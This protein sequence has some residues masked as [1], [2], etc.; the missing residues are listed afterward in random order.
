[1]TAGRAF[2]SVKRWMVDNRGRRQRSNFSVL[3]G[4]TANEGETHIRL[5]V[6]KIR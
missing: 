6:K 5:F 4:D 3:P 1:M 2:Q